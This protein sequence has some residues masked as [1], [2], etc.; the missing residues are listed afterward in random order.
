MIFG[1]GV[2]GPSDFQFWSKVL[3]KYFY[4][5]Q[6][7]VCNMKNR[8]KLIRET[9]R[10]LESFRD[11][12]YAGGFILVDRDDDPCVESVLKLFDLA[13][14]RMVRHTDKA[15]R[16]L[17]V[18]VA[19]KELESWYLADAVAIE[20]V[21]P[22]SGWRA[23]RDTSTAAKKRLRTLVKTHRGRNYAF[24]EIAFAKDIASKFN[25]DRARKHS[26]SFGYFWDILS[27]ACSPS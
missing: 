1:V 15:E 4:P 12:H 25:P 13:I 9:P 18:C 6:F 3:P 10:L 14:Q 21:I 27:N 5:I 19:I 23:P 7:D 17:H 24:N 22:G 2:E 11:S 26:A 16:Y 20:E 8:D